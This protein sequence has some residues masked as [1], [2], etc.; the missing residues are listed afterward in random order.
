MQ[1]S[2]E[3]RQGGFFFV[4]E[5]NM[6][7]N[8]DVEVTSTR[9]PKPIG[10]L[11]IRKDNAGHLRAV[12]IPYECDLSFAAKQVLIKVRVLRDYTKATGFRTTKSQNDLI[13]SLDGEDLAEVLLLLNKN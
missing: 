4:L 12:A 3:A 5:R 2:L 9:R 11:L 7:M 10:E 6:N 13:Q 1:A 8:N